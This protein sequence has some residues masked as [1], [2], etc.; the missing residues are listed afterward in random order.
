MNLIEAA[1]KVKE[2]YGPFLIAR[3]VSEKVGSTQKGDCILGE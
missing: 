2:I 3:L 1:T